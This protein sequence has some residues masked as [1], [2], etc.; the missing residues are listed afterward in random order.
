MALEAARL[1]VAWGWDESTIDSN[2][3]THG[4]WERFGTSTGILSGKPQRWDLDKLQQSD[5][6]NSGGNKLRKMI[7]GYFKQ[8]KKG[9]STDSST[10]T[11]KVTSSGATLREMS[12]SSAM[13][14]T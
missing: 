4:E 1:A 12:L 5:Q 6:N 9:S 10:G 11:T 13:E 3:R 8:L 14:M 7:K 2:V